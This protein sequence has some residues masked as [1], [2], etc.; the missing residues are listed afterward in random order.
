MR[1]PV[2]VLALTAAFL[3]TVLLSGRRRWEWVD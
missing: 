2:V 1:A 3:A